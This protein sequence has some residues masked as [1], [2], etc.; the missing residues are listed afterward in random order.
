ME[1]VDGLVGETG[2]GDA[3]LAVHVQPGARRTEVVGRHGDALKVRVQAPPDKGRAN[4]A[5][6]ALLAATFGV[7]DSSVVLVRG[8]SARAKRFRLVGLPAATA[9]AR[10]ATAIAGPSGTR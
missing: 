3:V 9:R 6:V 1:G 4:A 7:P 8:A 5:V 10:L 2:D